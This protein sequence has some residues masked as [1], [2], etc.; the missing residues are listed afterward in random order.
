MEF[1]TVCWLIV[2]PLLLQPLRR[3]A[4]T[5]AETCWT[6]WVT[7]QPASSGPSDR[8]PQATL[9]GECA[10]ASLFLL[11][12]ESSS[13]ARDIFHHVSQLCL[14]ACTDMVEH[15]SGFHSMLTA[16]LAKVQ[17]VCP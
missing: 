13:E 17:L 5:P 4:T 10:Y 14:V 1:C 12:V 7:T 15:V 6:A 8:R 16:A 9:C 2:L 11:Q 3:W